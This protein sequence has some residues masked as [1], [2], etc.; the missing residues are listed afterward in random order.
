MLGPIVR[1]P[2]K[3]L[4][5]YGLLLNA[6]HLPDHTVVRALGPKIC[7]KCGHRGADVQLDWSPHVNKR[8]VNPE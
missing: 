4:R 1:L 8:R 7:V 2:S 6:D 3:S 5:E